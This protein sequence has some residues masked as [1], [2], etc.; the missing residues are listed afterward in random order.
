MVN[1]SIWFFFYKQDLLICTVGQQAQIKDFH[2]FFLI[3][4]ISFNFRSKTSPNGL[5][6]RHFHI[7]IYFF[8]LKSF[9]WKDLWQPLSC[10]L[11]LMAASVLSAVADCIL[12]LVNCCWW[13]PMSCQ[14]LLM[15]PASL[16]SAV[17]DGSLCLVSCCWWQ[18]LSCHLLLMAGSVLSPVADGSL[19]LVSCYW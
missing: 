5:K 1:V 8:L 16:L 9:L 13:Q 15:M 14:L 18:P 12:C 17:A 2:T 4:Y 6:L 7:S 10:H 19:C 3:S 11:L